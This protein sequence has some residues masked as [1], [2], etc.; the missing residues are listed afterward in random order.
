M[1]NKFNSTKAQYPRNKTFIDIFE[2]QVKENP[3]NI[4]VVF[5]GEKLTYKELNKKANSLGK[6]IAKQRCESRFHSFNNG[7]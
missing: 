5:E 2:N 1:L 6:N 3:D 7:R 4:A